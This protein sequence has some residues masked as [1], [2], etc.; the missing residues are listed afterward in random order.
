MR[1]YKRLFIIFTI[2]ISLILPAKIFALEGS[3]NLSC[4]K[5]S[6][7]PGE[8]T[9]CNISYI[10]SSGSLTGFQTNVNLSSNLELVSSSK[11]SAWEGSA[12]RL[13]ANSRENSPKN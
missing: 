13:N 7:K 12:E 6:L 2:M 1:V 5:N 8:Q 11:N 10:A 3:L 4:V 9:T